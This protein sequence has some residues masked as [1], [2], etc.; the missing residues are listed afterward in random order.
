MGQRLVIE[1]VTPFT[2]GDTTNNIYY[3][4]SAYTDSALEEIAEFTNKVSSYYEKFYSK[5]SGED[6]FNLA[7]LEAV[8]GMSP[9]YKESIEYI[10]NLLGEPYESSHVSRNDGMIAFAEEDIELNRSWSEGTVRITW[11][12]QRM[13]ILTL[14]KQL[15]I[16]GIW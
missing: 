10:S 16:F 15:L 5:G 2:N 12:L 8:S 9:D 14:K 4:W 6:F 13:A 11:H 1:N 3:H 7:C